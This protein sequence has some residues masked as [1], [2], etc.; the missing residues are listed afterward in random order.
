MQIFNI[1]ASDAQ[2]NEYVLTSTGGHNNEISGIEGTSIGNI[3]IETSANAIN[4]YN[5]EG[6]EVAI[7]T[8]DGTTLSR[9][10]A[11]SDMESRDVVDG[12]YVAAAGNKVEKVIVK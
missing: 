4:V 10:T 8:I 9:F 7:Y 11:V 1:L 6:Y 3:R 5:A 12:F 2:A